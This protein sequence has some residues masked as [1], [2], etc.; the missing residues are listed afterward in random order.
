MIEVLSDRI[1]SAQQE[2]SK[3]LAL[4]N[5][6][7]QNEAAFG[8]QKMSMKEHLAELRGLH[9]RLDENLSFFKINSKNEG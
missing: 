1:G 4:I 7:E 8:T 2:I 5:Y 3:A 6:I 9:K